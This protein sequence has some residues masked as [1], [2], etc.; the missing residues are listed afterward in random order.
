MI[1]FLRA[2]E[3]VPRPRKDPNGEPLDQRK[4]IVCSASWVDWVEE[5]R[6]TQRPAPTWSEAVRTLAAEALMARGF[7]KPSTPKT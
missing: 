4:Q 5:W 1:Q 6:L 3:R 7:P 2:I